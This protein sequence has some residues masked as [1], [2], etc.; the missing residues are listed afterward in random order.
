M[1]KKGENEAGIGIMEMFGKAGKGTWAT[2]SVGSPNASSP[3]G[4][5]ISHSRLRSLETYRATAFPSS[6]SLAETLC[7]KERNT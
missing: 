6:F 1:G 4:R 7:G 5:G 2:I 3:N